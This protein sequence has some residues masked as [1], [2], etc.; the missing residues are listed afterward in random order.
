VNAVPSA[1]SAS[2]WWSWA[3]ISAPSTEGL[4]VAVLTLA[5]LGLRASQ[6]HQSLFGDEVLA[7]GEI[8]GH[9][10]RYTVDT[11]SNGV[12]S[13][14]P[15][16]FVLAW[17]S[18]KLGDP[19]VWIRL[20]SLL[21]GTATI[22]VVYLLGREV[23]G[24]RGAL[25]AAAIIAA[26]PF[27]TYYGVEA[28][29]YATMEFFVALSTLGL[30]RAVRTGSRRDWGLYALAAAAAAYS[31]YTAVF[32]LVTQAV[33][34]IWACRQHPCAALTANA[35]AIVLYLPWLP[36]LHGS[37][38]GDYALLEPLTAGHVLQ[39]VLRPV[40]GYPYASLNAIPTLEG[41]VVIAA[42]ALLG[43][44]VLV[45]RSPDWWRRGDRGQR[46]LLIVVLALATPVGLLLYSLL[47]TDLWSARNLIAS[48]PA[49]CLVL[50][51]LLVALASRMRPVLTAVVL[52]LLVFGTLRAISPRYARPP[53][54]TVAEYL[55]RVARP[56]DPVLMVS[57]ALVFDDAIPAQFTRP[58]RVLDGIPTRWPRLRA[59][60]PAYV[61]VD[62]S[63][64]HA[65]APAVLRPPGFTLVARRHYVGLAPFSLL[66]YRALG[67]PA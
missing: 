24:R 47:A 51:S 41:L 28:R 37:A 16:F 38:L 4:L 11:V 42:V 12:E 30:L 1:R 66:T 49:Q 53:Y 6:L 25:L 45:H 55:D 3:G 52:G 29:P 20:P 35:L 50:A 64:V 23:V 62:D 46:R 18:A 58:H 65:L 32:V 34:G 8:S 22:P 40:V 7:V 61:V 26:S 39:D 14:P 9:T 67:P 21:L 10:L 60:A 31:H 59:G 13:S 36:S 33:W 43:L 48:A 15:L 56:G 17:L 63:I 57:S 54:R 2:D 44:L 27:A 5:T 19:T